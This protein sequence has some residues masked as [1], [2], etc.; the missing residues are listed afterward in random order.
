MSHSRGRKAA[1]FVTALALV[2]TTLVPLSATPAMAQATTGVL[3]GTVADPT[4]AAIPNAKVTAK[5][6]DTGKEDTTT[7]SGEGVYSFPTLPPGKYTVT[8]EAPGFKRAVTTD[9]DVRI[10]TENRRDV[11]MVAGAVEETVT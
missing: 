10:G 9:V 5:N 7:A 1:A 8:V 3:T 6:Q 2:L 11:A 4:G